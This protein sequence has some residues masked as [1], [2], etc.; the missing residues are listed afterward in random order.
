M[1]HA[2]PVDNILDVFQFLKRKEL[3]ECRLVNNKFLDIVKNFGTKLPLHPIEVLEN[4]QNG[5]T[6]FQNI[7]F[8]VMHKN[9]MKNKLD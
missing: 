6:A 1:S 8:I 4:D 3:E 7:L 5:N 2:I 9:F